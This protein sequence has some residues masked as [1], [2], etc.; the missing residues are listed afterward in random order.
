MR[1]LLLRTIAGTGLMLFGLT[2]SLQAQ[3][4]R[5][6]E[7][8]HRDREGYY[9]GEQW[10]AHFFEKV[11]DD[12]NHVQSN[13]FTSGGDQYRIARA[14]QELNELQNDFAG[15]RYDERQVDDVIATLQR[16]VA[17]N[18]LSERD[19]DILSDD[20]NRLREFRERHSDWGV[21]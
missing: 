18:R 3:R 9:R 8:Y 4:P 15:H 17:D 13:W 7:A 20:L 12:L 5:D 19:R 21:R 2:A 1:H 10:R 11:R 16:V 14:K 6:D